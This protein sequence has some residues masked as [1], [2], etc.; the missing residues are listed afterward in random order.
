M[1]LHLIPFELHVLM[2]TTYLSTWSYYL[3]TCSGAEEKRVKLAQMKSA[4]VATWVQR[5]TY[6][7]RQNIVLSLRRATTIY[8]CNEYLPI[9]CGFNSHP[10][11]AVE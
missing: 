7:H 8:I 4:S 2:L 5:S 1:R 10:G 3:S 11:T 9:V 6:G